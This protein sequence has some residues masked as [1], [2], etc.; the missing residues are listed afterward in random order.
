MNYKNR[1]KILIADDD[2]QFSR[3]A[4]DYLND[5]GFDSRFVNNG[6]EAQRVIKEWKPRLVI[7]D[8]L[9]PEGNALDILK[10]IKDNE[11]TSKHNINLM[12]VS[13]HNSL[14]NVKQ[15]FKHGAVDY[16]VKPMEFE[17]LLKRVVF[18]LRRT[19]RI[20]EFDKTVVGNPEEASFLLYLTELVLRTSAV[21]KDA[22]EAL[23]NITK[24]V[25]SKMDGVRCNIVRYISPIEGVVVSSSDDR[26]AAGIELNLQK[27]PEIISS[28][29]SG[30]TIAIDNLDSDSD[31]KIIKHLFKDISFNSL[32]VC[33]IQCNKEI[34]GVLS[35]RM[36][37]ERKPVTNNE[38]R[39][40]AMAALI[41]GLVVN[42]KNLSK[43]NSLFKEAS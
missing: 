38:M 28:V 19:R 33:P 4:S 2:G 42:N 1:L 11:V 15:T 25:A 20:Q 13:G 12:V 9:L 36:P 5:H 23:F 21:E 40:I 26:K 14:S 3:R 37:K 24:M 16:L 29:T 30:E 7:C 6:K 34:Y 8:L 10:F 18:Q 39:F 17:D 32:L 41:A 27:Y 22:S 35:I 43:I 31:L